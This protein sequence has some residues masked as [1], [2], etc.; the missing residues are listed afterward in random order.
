MLVQEILLEVSQRWF[1]PSKLLSRLVIRVLFVD[2]FPELHHHCDLGIVPYLMR[3]VNLV[4]WTSFAGPSS[5]CGSVHIL[6]SSW[7]AAVSVLNDPRCPRSSHSENAGQS[8]ILSI[9]LSISLN[10][11]GR[12][13]QHSRPGWEAVGLNLPLQLGNWKDTHTQPS[14]FFSTQVAPL[15]FCFLQ[16]L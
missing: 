7:T 1:P 14:L 10:Y 15:T 13:L 12:K 11:S 3:N 16:R 2:F 6:F 8:P 9:Y 4:L 5:V